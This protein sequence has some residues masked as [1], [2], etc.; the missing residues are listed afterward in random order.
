V[1]IPS[2]KNANI[3]NQKDKVSQGVT[4]KISPGFFVVNVNDKHWP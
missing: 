3:M 2:K 1:V 4:G